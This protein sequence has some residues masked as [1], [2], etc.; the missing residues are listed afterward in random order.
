MVADLVQKCEGGSTFERRAVPPMPACRP[1]HGHAGMVPMATSLAYRGHAMAHDHAQAI[2]CGGWAL[3]ATSCTGH[4]GP[5]RGCGVAAD[6]KRA[7]RQIATFPR[8]GAVLCFFFFS[9]A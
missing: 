2:D 8:V 9:D 7:W 6:C 1:S 4:E 3:D 5:A